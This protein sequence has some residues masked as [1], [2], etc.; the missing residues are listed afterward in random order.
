MIN[1]GPVSCITFCI[2]HN[3]V[4]INDTVTASHFSYSLWPAV[5][6]QLCLTTYTAQD[7][8]VAGHSLTAHTVCVPFQLWLTTYTV[9]PV[10][11]EVRPADQSPGVFLWQNVSI[12]WHKASLQLNWPRCPSKGPAQCDQCDSITFRPAQDIPGITILLLPL[13]VTGHSHQLI[14]LPL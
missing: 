6:F 2:W 11:V 4:R 14:I 5:S 8:V 13:S 10:D 1:T 12:V 3:Y 7:T 9:C